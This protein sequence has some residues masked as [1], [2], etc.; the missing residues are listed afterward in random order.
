MVFNLKF[1]GKTITNLQIK[2]WKLDC[3][4]HFCLLVLNSEL[5][6]YCFL[7]N[8]LREWL[9]SVE[10]TIIVWRVSL[11]CSKAVFVLLASAFVELLQYLYLPYT[12]YGGGGGGGWGVGGGY[13]GFSLSV[14]P[15]CRDSEIRFR[16]ISWERNDGIWPNFAHAL[17]L[18]ISRLELLH[19]NFHQIVKEL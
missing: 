4:S 8:L 17:I 14:M 19:V 3:I 5:L 2:F 13:T 18:I 10:I 12:K 1:F 6:D 15:S 7:K 9:S 16:S 11:F